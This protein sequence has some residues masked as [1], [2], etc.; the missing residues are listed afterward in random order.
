VV[1]FF[2]ATG[3][4]WRP[5]QMAPSLPLLDA[6]GELGAL[7]AQVDLSASLA[8]PLLAQRK[9]CRPLP[10]SHSTPTLHE[11]RTAA[12]LPPLP[13]PSARREE[14][15]SPRPK[16]VHSRVFERQRLVL[17]DETSAEAN[18]KARSNNY[19]PMRGGGRRGSISAA[20]YF[21]SKDLSLTRA[22][23]SPHATPAEAWLEDVLELVR[24][25]EDR[26][27]GRRE[28][29]REGVHGL[30]R[31]GIGRRSLQEA[32]ME[33]AAIGRLF[34][35]L[36]VH[37]FGMHQSLSTVLETLSMEA[38]GRVAVRARLGGR[39]GQR[40]GRGS[41]LRECCSLTSLRSLPS[42]VT[43]FWRT[44]ILIGE[45]LLRTTLHTELLDLLSGLEGEV[46]RVRSEAE[47]RDS[48]A[49][50]AHAKLA[51]ALEAATRLS[52]HERGRNGELEAS[53][54]REKE[55]AEA[56]EGVVA[57]QRDE[58]QRRLM[59]NQRLEIELAEAKRQYSMCAACAR[60]WGGA[61]TV[62]EM[63]EQTHTRT[64]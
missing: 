22:A 31:M 13:S 3:S 41:E 38:K 43:S 60:R 40:G 4:V 24:M 63:H 36:F 5:F 11:S 57:S 58:I 20:L 7:L 56:A 28:E 16:A 32:G 50:A 62:A 10:F 47:A 17:S 18:E 6:G 35:L 25:R 15:E 21:E 48:E 46:F 39:G 1:P 61:K 9:P 26:K 19:S 53:L 23:H 42:G 44:K 30:E 33:G 12:L 51:E 49:S 2:Q 52:D 27:G 55:R 54:E 29:R 14:A 59:D 45:R 8:Q 64:D 37:S 34:Q